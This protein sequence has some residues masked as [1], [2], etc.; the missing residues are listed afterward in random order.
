MT[1]KFD[2]FI[3][4]AEMRTGSNFLESNLDQFDDLKC[5]GET[6]NPYFMVSP[7]LKDLFGVSVKARDEDPMLLVEKM[8]ENTKGIPGFRFFHDHDP[9]VFNALIDDPHC[10]KVILTRN[11]LEAYVSRKIAWATDQW[12][13]NNVDDAIKKKAMFVSAEF[14]KLFYRMKDFQLKI[15]NRLQVTGQT[16]FYIDYEDAQNLDVINGLAKFLGAKG[17]I[18]EF[19]GKFKKQNPEPMSEKV[20]NYEVLKQ[21]VAKVDPFDL[22]RVPNFAQSRPAA[23]SSYIASDKPPMLF[24]PIK[25]GPTDEVV[26]WL[27]AAGPLTEDLNQKTLR[28]WKNQNKQH[29]TFTVLRHPVVRLHSVFC[30]YFVT[31]GPDTYWDIKEAVRDRYD[32]DLPENEPDASWTLDRHRAAFLQFIAFVDRNLKGQTSLRL[33]PAWVSQNAVVSG[34]AGFA[35]PDHLLREE[36][37]DTGLATLWGEVSNK[38]PPK[39]KDKAQDQPYGL[40][41]VYSPEI[42]AEI[43]KIYQRDYMMFGF[44]P[45][46]KS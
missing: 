23:V 7:E 33:D 24:M 3:I 30:R 5:Y 4:F 39:W 6:F 26:N 31:H 28:A 45:W 14:E 46:D 17:E 32:I 8:K 13:L 38:K 10:A 11:M 12:Q 22:D 19:A 43:R 36:T 15:K 16:A 35:L 41:E 20:E 37:L 1:Q 18:T 40:G 27:Q 25:G 21:T 9:R 44:K 29:R 34:F 2:C 42:E